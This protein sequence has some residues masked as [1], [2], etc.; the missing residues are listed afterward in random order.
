MDFVSKE[1]RTKIMKSI[2]SKDTKHEVILRKTLFK[3]GLRYRINYKNLSG[4]PDIVFV[5]KKLAIFVHGCFWHQ[6]EDNCEITN[7]PASNKRFWSDKFKKNMERDKR[8]IKEIETMGW[9]T[10]TLWECQILDKNRNPRDLSRI[11]KEI[12]KKLFSN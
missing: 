9:R 3:N 7:K 2:K 12:K 4:K 1:K 6:H 10:L 5:S 8:N 11:L